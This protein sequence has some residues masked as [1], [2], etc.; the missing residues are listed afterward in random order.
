M[1]KRSVWVLA[2]LFA[3]CMCHAEPAPVS[4]TA[5]QQNIQQT[6][7]R[8]GDWMLAHRQ[9]TPGGRRRDTDW[10]VGAWYAGVYALYDLTRDTRYLEPLLAMERSTGWR[11]GPS[12]LFADDQCIAQTYLDLYQYVRQDTVLIAH[13]RGVCDAMMSYPSDQSME[14]HMQVC[15]KGEWS[16]CDALFMAPPVWSKLAQITGE[17]KYLDFMDTKWRKTKAYLYDPEERLYYRDSAYFNKREANGSKVF[18]SRGNGWVLAGLA[19]VLDGM[20]QAYPAR[21]HYEQQF[22][23]MAQRVVACQPA[24]GLW[25]PSLLDPDGYPIAETSGS[26][27]FCYALAWGINNGLLKRDAFEPPTLKAWSGLLRCV[28]AEGKLT[29]VQPIGKDPRNFDP[30]STEVYGVGAFLLAGSEVIK[31][32]L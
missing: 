19:R 6:L 4:L 28:S 31:L 7:C 21:P 17:I 24:D 10:T 12:P 32:R 22:V 30:D 16:W 18:W 27:F 13:T 25:R 26:G 2:G 20:P 14:N 1:R 23:E 15:Y 11:V 9:E 3:V 5:R 29:Q 8:V